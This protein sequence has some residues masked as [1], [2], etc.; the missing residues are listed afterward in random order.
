MSGARRIAAIVF[1]AVALLALL[2]VFLHGAQLE[3]TRSG[4]IVACALFSPWSLVVASVFA[5]TQATDL[6]L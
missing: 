5:N 1:V 4:I 3:W 2:P 6:A